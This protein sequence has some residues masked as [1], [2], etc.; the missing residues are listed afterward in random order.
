MGDCEYVL[1]KVQLPKYHGKS[2]I[3]PPLVLSHDSIQSHKPVI[4]I[5]DSSILESY[6]PFE[7]SFSESKPPICEVPLNPFPSEDFGSVGEEKP[8]SSSIL[9]V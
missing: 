1:T 7:I 8:S 9:Y 6:N 5:V 3:S 4:V 2:T